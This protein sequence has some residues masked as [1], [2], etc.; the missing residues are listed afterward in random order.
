MTSNYESVRQW[1]VTV[2][3]DEALKEMLSLKERYPWLRCDKTITQLTKL[4]EDLPK[5][6]NIILHQEKQ[7]AIHREY[8]RVNGLADTAIAEA[9]KAKFNL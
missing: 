4:E 7:N 2:R 1:A 8:I 5:I 9:I 6:I 3:V